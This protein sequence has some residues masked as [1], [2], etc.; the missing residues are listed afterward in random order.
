M[1]SILF[2]IFMTSAGASEKL[3]LRHAE[4][5]AVAST[6][7]DASGRPVKFDA[8]LCETFTI[9]A[10]SDLT[11]NETRRVLLSSLSAHLY[12]VVPRDGGF[13]I[14]HARMASRD[15]HDVAPC[16]PQFSDVV[17][18][19][20]RDPMLAMQPT[21]LVRSLTRDGTL[22]VA[23]SS[24]LIII[25]DDAETVQRLRRDLIKGGR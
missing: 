13:V 14:R 18:W 10:E 5:P 23:P 24:D 12:N 9:E 25:S 21:H 17:T 3:W 6:L 16:R 1:T 19:A 11:P 7:A 20:F 4:L 8:G 22:H 15:S 2:A